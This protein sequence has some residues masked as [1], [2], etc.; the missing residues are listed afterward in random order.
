MKRII[1]LIHTPLPPFITIAHP[2]TSPPPPNYPPPL[3]RY[4]DT[5]NKLPNYFEYINNI[6]LLNE[7]VV[8]W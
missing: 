1:F 8:F 7:T 5:P 4:I 6:Q 3:L 2:F